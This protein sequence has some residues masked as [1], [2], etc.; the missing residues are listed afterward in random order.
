MPSQ[1]GRSAMPSAVAEVQSWA[2]ISAVHAS[3]SLDVVTEIASQTLGTLQQ[4]GDSVDRQS[5]R[6]SSKPQSSM[7]WVQKAVA[8]ASHWSPTVWV[9]VPPPLV[10]ASLPRG[11]MVQP[12]VPTAPIAPTKRTAAIADRRSTFSLSPRASTGRARSGRGRREGSAPC[13][14]ARSRG[15]APACPPRRS[16]LRPRPPRGRGR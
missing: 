9:V 13:G 2:A 4:V 11:W 5:A 6:L 8:R 7:T 3:S 14:T 16:R 10:P 12:W 1:L 15:F